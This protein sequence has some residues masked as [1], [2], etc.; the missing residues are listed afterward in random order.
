MSLFIVITTKKKIK[1]SLNGVELKKLQ[2]GYGVMDQKRKF[3]FGRG[4][5]RSC[6][7]KSIPPIEL[8]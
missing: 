8:E 6:V 5:A 2:C 4:A 1:K 3:L 7:A